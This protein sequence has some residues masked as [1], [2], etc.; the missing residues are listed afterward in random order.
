MWLLRPRAHS[1][2]LTDPIPR[3][4][5]TRQLYTAENLAVGLH[6]GCQSSFGREVGPPPSHITS[7]SLM[8][9]ATCPVLMQALQAGRV[10]WETGK[11]GFLRPAVG[12]EVLFLWDS[13]ATGLPKALPALNY[14]TS[15]TD[16]TCEVWM[17]L[18]LSS[19]SFSSTSSWFGEGKVPS[20]CR[21]G[22]QQDPL[23]CYHGLELTVTPKQATDNL[24]VPHP[25]ALLKV[26][27]TCSDLSS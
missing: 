7:F 8:A 18:S 16:L 3:I 14:I 13:R 4:C 19:K 10:S 25:T 17:H 23:A 20:F 24:A 12:F 27:E 5:W 2:L 11:R 6:R 15:W 9:W 22:F 1:H 21:A 26:E